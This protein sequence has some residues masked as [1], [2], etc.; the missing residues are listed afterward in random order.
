MKMTV[1]KYSNF[2]ILQ[3]LY[4]GQSPSVYT[5]DR[6]KSELPLCYKS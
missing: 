5:M 6:G 1:V 2:A 4:I 3:K